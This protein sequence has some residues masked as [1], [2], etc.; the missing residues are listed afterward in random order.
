MRREGQRYKSVQLKLYTSFLSD[1]IHGRKY[2]FAWNE[3]A[4][5]VGVHAA[6]HA[7]CY[8]KPCGHKTNVAAHVAG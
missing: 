1:V 3:S 4:Y 2:G 8:Y 5:C 7:A 6:F